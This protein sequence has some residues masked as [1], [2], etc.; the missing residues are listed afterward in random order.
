MLFVVAIP[1]AGLIAGIALLWG[2]GLSW[3]QLAVFAGMYF[4]TALG[5]TLGFH[6]LFTHRAFKTTRPIKLILGIL[7]SMA[8]EGQ[9]LKWVAVHRR[10]HQ[11][12]DTQD[13]PHS[14]HVYG[15][16]FLAMVRG[17]W[18]A[19]VGWMFQ[20]DA[21][22]LDR[23]IDDLVP[24]RMLRAVSR[25]FPLWV[26]LGLVIPAVLGGVLTGTWT[27][28]LVGFLWGG[29][30]RIF[31]V[32]HMTWS[33]NSVCHLWGRRPFPSR[34]ESRNNLVFG[35]LGLGEGWHNNHHAFPISARHGLRWWQI[36]ITYLV[37]RALQAMRLAWKVQVP[38]AETIAGRLRQQSGRS[39]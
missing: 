34:D 37:I 13:D 4:L 8:V 12:S 6:R 19:H 20:P 22:G 11:C 28:A 10:H 39:R 3:V 24:D 17:L 23:Y 14:P 27:G 16:G 21:P 2:Y 36:D 26:V 30:A 9:L 25:L 31:L 38:C 32:H 35:V 29:L 15:H 18:H 33:I 5:V 7:G 1:F